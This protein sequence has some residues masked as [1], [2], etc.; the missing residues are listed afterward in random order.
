MNKILKKLGTW[1][2]SWFVLVT[3]LFN[4]DGEKKHPNVNPKNV[5]KINYIVK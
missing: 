3:F 1:G 5:K 2:V 4:F